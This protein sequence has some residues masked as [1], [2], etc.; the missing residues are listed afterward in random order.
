MDF[1]QAK[2]SAKAFHSHCETD[3]LPLQNSYISIAT[4]AGKPC[5]RA[6]RHSAN[7]RQHAAQ[8]TA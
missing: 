7:V 8:T 1:L 4:P 6:K 2:G 3:T 5:P